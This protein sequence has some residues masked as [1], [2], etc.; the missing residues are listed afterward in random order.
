MVSV[1]TED[2]D[3]PSQANDSIEVLDGEDGSVAGILARR[4]VL[5]DPGV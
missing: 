5:S 1:P 3:L 2:D 4:D